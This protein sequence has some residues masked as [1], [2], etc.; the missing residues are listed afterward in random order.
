MVRYSAAK[1]D[2]RQYIFDTLQE[3]SLDAPDRRRRHAAAVDCFN[4]I[5]H[6]R[7]CN[8]FGSW[9]QSDVEGPKFPRRR[10]GANDRKGGAG[11]IG[12]VRKHQCRAPTTLLMPECRVEID[13]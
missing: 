5:D 6:D 10:D 12:G 4:L 11:V 2:K 9:R 1:S 13:P 3:F 8:L 7:T